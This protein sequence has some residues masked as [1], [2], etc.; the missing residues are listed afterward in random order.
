MLRDGV[1]TRG[2]NTFNN[3][4]NFCKVTARLEHGLLRVRAYE[5]EMFPNKKV[6][7]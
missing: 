1:T 2:N 5:R 7:S 3:I 6:A 4:C